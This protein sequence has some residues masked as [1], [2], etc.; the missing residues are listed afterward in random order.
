MFEQFNLAFIHKKNNSVDISLEIYSKRGVNSVILKMH[1]STGICFIRHQFRVCDRPSYLHTDVF[2]SVFPVP[3]ATLELGF[4]IFFSVLV[5]VSAV[6]LSFHDSILQLDKFS[7][8][9]LK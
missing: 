4:R 3:E 9:Y 5:L 6:S 1:L 2:T 7:F 8:Y